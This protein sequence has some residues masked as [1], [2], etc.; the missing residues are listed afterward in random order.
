MLFI[1]HIID[2]K[3]EEQVTLI[4]SSHILQNIRFFILHKILRLDEILILFW[5][6]WNLNTCNNCLLNDIIKLKH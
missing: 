1:L 4:K 3:I 2:V 5:S 6:E